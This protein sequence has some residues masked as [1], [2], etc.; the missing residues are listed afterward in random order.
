M[1]NE[2]CLSVKCSLEILIIIIVL[3]DWFSGVVDWLMLP[4]F[5]SPKNMGF[6]CTCLV[7][8]FSWLS[9]GVVAAISGMPYAQ[10]IA[11]GT[12]FC[13]E[14]LNNSVW[15]VYIFF[16][17]V[18]VSQKMEDGKVCTITIFNHSYSFGFGFVLLKQKTS[19]DL[20]SSYTLSKVTTN[21]I[22]T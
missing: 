17:I 18:L 9:L 1:L 12:N 10:H 3:R 7:S 22:R 20:Y 21:R 13:T 6:H 16:V 5:D 15:K 19:H 2:L 8:D 11:P 14:W 4:I